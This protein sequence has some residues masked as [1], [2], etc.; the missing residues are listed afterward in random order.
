MIELSDVKNSESSICPPE[1]AT[2]PKS[3]QNSTKGKTKKTSVSR[4]RWT[5][6]KRRDGLPV[7]AKSTNFDS[8]SVINTGTKDVAYELVKQDIPAYEVF[9]KQEP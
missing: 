7:K 2:P 8:W 4:T 1:I 3:D 6:I 5:L 9:E